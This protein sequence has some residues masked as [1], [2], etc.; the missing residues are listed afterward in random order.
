MN[1]GLGIVVLIYEH[2]SSYFMLYTTGLVSQ[3]SARG[4][5]DSLT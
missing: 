3:A 1:P 4:I 5:M 2:S